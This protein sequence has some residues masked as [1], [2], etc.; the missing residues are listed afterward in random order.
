M[1][2][3]TDNSGCRS[4]IQYSFSTTHYF[5][6]KILSQRFA[7]Y[8]S[9]AILKECSLKFP[10]KIISRGCGHSKQFTNELHT[11]LPQFWAR[12]LRQYDFLIQNM[13][14]SEINN[15]SCCSQLEKKKCLKMEKHGLRMS[16]AKV[17]FLGLLLT[18]PCALILSSATS[19]PL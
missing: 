6:S 2:D 3:E 15:K 10:T 16:A 5:P 12:I 11:S 17:N 1:A 18:M 4:W 13:A 8:N 7:N 9:V 19:S 14:L